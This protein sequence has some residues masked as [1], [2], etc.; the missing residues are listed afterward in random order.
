MVSSTTQ[1]EPPM[2]GQRSTAVIVGTGLLVPVPHSVWR[3]G[4]GYQQ[5]HHL[6]SLLVMTFIKCSRISAVLEEVACLAPGFA[7]VEISSDLYTL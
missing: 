3:R 7:K 6:V 1:W 5:C 2:A 4:S